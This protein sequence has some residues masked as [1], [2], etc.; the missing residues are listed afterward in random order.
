MP[1]NG[2]SDIEVQ[3]AT[4]DKDFKIVDW[5]S[6]DL[7]DLLRGLLDKDPTKRYTI[8][9]IKSHKWFAF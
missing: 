3:I 8:Q 1:F 2:E 9:E 7:Q 4:K 5:M 6:E